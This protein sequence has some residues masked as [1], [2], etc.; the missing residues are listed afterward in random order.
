MPPLSENSLPPWWPLPNNR[1]EHQKTLPLQHTSVSCD[2]YLPVPREERT[3]RP[4]PS[5]PVG[6]HFLSRGIL[7]LEILVLNPWLCL[8]PWELGS[9][10]GETDMALLENGQK[11]LQ[12]IWVSCG[13]THTP[14]QLHSKISPC[15]WGHLV[16]SSRL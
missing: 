10:E 7:G 11:K 15:S 12:K 14:H 3:P 2:D 16:S 4:T 8:S 1:S 9:Y 5:P 6:K 13:H